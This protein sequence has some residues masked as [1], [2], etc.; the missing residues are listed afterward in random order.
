MYIYI[1]RIAAAYIHYINYECCILQ[2][3]KV[4]NLFRK[5]FAKNS[6]HK[7][8][9]IKLDPKINRNKKVCRFIFKFVC[10]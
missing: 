9:F 1:Q 6:F 8:H 3:I 10:S 4:G 2:S 5:E 7:T